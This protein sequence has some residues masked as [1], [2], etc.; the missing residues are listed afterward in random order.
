MTITARRAA[1]CLCLL[2]AAAPALAVQ[3]RLAPDAILLNDGWNG[4]VA[5]IQDDPDSPDA[6]WLTHDGVTNNKT[7]QVSFPTP[8]NPLTSGAGL[9][10]FRVLLR[11][12]TSAGVPD[13]GGGSPAYTVELWENGALVA[14]VASGNIAGGPVVVS[15]TWDAAGRDATLI[16]CVVTGGRAGGGGTTRY[17]EVGA[18]EWNAE[19]TAAGN[20]TTL[21][22]GTDPAAAPSLCPD[23][24]ATMLDAFSFV[25][26]G[27]SDQ[28]NDVTVDLTNGTSESLSLIEITSQSGATVYGSVA[29]PVPDPVTI[30]LTTNPLTATASLTEYRVRITPK[31]HADMPAPQGLQYTIQGT[32]TAFTPA[33]NS[34]AGSDAGSDTVTIDNRSPDNPSGFS[35]A[36]GDNQVQLSWTDPVD[37]DF[38]EVIIVR[39]VGGALVGGPVEGQTYAVTDAV[40][41]G[42][43][44][45]V[46]N[47]ASSPWIDTG[48]ANGTTYWY[49]IFARDNPCANWSTGVDSG[50]HTP[51]AAKNDVA[52]DPATSTVDGCNQITV[53]V[54]FGGDDNADSS[55]T[56]R[57]GP[58]ATGPWTDVCVG[59]T[60]PSPR[61]CIDTGV[62][63]SST[64]WH[65]VEF[66]DGDGVDTTNAPNPQEVGPRS[67]PACSTNDTTSFSNTAEGS[68]CRQIT[69]IGVFQGDANDNGWTVVEHGPSATGPWTTACGRL[70]GPSP[71]Q[72]PVTGDSD[73]TLTGDTWV[74][75]TYQDPD[76]VPATNS[77]VLGPITLDCTGVTDA[78][79]PAVLLL[80]PTR[81][82][83][84][85]GVDRAKVLI[86]DTGGVSQVRW[87]IDG[88][89][90]TACAGPA[91]TENTNYQGTNFCGA[92]CTVYEIELDT[93]GL[94]NDRHRLTVEVT[95]AS[96]EANVARVSQAFRSSN[97]SPTKPG[98]GGLLLRRSHGSQLCN[99]CHNLP[100]HGSHTTSGDY[101]NWT[102]ECLSCHTPHDTA[103]I[104]L[105]QKSLRTPNSGIATVNFH[106]DDAVVGTFGGN[107]NPGDQA[108]HNPDELSF[109]GDRSQTGTTE[110]N[111]PYDDGI[112]ETCHTKTKFWR[113]TETVGKHGHNAGTRCL[114]CHL[115][116]AGFKGA[117]G[118]CRGCHGNTGDP[119]VGGP[120]MRRAVLPDFTKTSHHVGDGTTTMGGSLT[121]HDCVVCHAEGRVNPATGDTETVSMYHGGDGGTISIDLKDADNWDNADPTNGAVSIVYSYDKNAVASSA[122]TA[123]FWNSGNATWVTE[124]STEL[125]PFCLTCHDAN[126]A[127]QSRNQTDTECAPGGDAGNPFCD[128][129]ISNENDQW[130][131]GRVTDIASRAAEAW[132]VANFCSTSGDP[133]VSDADC[134]SGE[135]CDPSSYLAQ[136]RDQPGEPRYDE[137]CP[138]GAGCNIDD[139]PQGTYSRHAIRGATV[140]GGFSGAASVYSGTNATWDTATYW[141]RT[142]VTWSSNSVMGCADCHTTDGAN[143][144]DGNA[145]GSNS[146]YLLKDGGGLAREGDEDPEAG[147]GPYNCYMC[148]QQTWYDSS[149]NT[150]TGNLSDYFDSTDLT[151]SGP[152]AGRV[153]EGAP[154]GNLY[155]IACLNCHGGVRAMEVDPDP[156]NPPDFSTPQFGT[157]HGTSQIYR[158]GEDGRGTDSKGTPLA[159]PTRQTYR[160]TNGN[161]LR[162]YYP[163][164][165]SAASST[166]YTLSGSKGDQGGDEF[167]GCTKHGGGQG[168]TR[169]VVR[170]LNY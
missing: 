98:G 119:A 141:N 94:A 110:P 70:T 76:G 53:T 99:D 124:T 107:G 90:L 116:D 8:A 157:I 95:D 27:N 14:T 23:G 159:S 103:N 112:C 168:L 130:D 106:Y 140:T 75:I 163:Q 6:N 56:F 83:V 67:T 150:H 134:P 165:W 109:L 145:H 79:A 32:V 16:E 96:V 127:S 65:Q 121:D 123:E 61:S 51:A 81:D 97:D 115:H 100:T 26:D 93:T 118:G 44:V 160:F 147:D 144:T 80:S 68:S 102:L 104:F 72:C 92:D 132:R 42:T 126:G 19:T 73:N 89:P 85:S 25:T 149:S 152:D 46:G 3:E 37:A 22:D 29:A 24:P 151:G 136:E 108:A 38:L 69:V 166:C 13:A 167:G 82:A 10:E 129:T 62:L 170:N 137:A 162:Y 63:E 114:E 111:A 135:T 133:C 138:G 77:E 59:V 101:G 139:P 71:R 9:Q 87:A 122:G 35:G 155:G 128:A 28:V 84:V 21:G 64:Y 120:N 20:T 131:R 148:H 58:S 55:T 45:F 11:K 7:L 57:R 1:I 154:G 169:P 49:K 17:V 18:V 30:P 142:Y 43:V 5:D 66:S 105:I 47:D 143:T 50:P 146:E 158:T 88:D 12:V 78:D 153:P 156:A 52:P 40:G 41:D 36:A 54:T 91:C 31:L 2:A 48:A 60:G 164:T 125:D 15:G 34:T 4:T 161:S 33:T 86:Y 117:G 113:N 39:K 74:Q